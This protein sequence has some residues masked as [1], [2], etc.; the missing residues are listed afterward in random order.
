MVSVVIPAYNEEKA[1]PHTLR[2]LFC[3]GGDYEVIVV[4]GGSTDCTRAIVD[5]FGFVAT[6]IQ[7]STFFC[8]LTP[9]AS[10]LTPAIDRSKRPCLPDEYGRQT[11]PGRVAPLSSR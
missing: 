6:S 3:Q 4:D 10:S 8:A 11:G 2:E 7:H 1:L 9:Y 5:S